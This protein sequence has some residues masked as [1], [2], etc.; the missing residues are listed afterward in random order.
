MLSFLELVNAS[1]TKLEL[2]GGTN[3][4][5]MQRAL[6]IRSILE[7]SKITGLNRKI[8]MKPRKWEETPDGA[9]K[10]VSALQ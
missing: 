3:P 6:Q 10:K 4:G 1:I 8:Q 5:V 9:K 7:R 2:Q